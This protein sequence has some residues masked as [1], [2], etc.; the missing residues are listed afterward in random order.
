MSVR[1]FILALGREVGRVARRGRHVVSL[2]AMLG[3]AVAASSASAALI[4]SFPSVNA[5]PTA[6]ATPVTVLVGTEVTE[7]NYTVNSFTGTWSYT[8]SN[9]SLPD[10]TM[11]AVSAPG[12][13][14]VFTTGAPDYSLPSATN[15]GVNTSGATSSLVSGSSYNLMNL[16]FLVPQ[17]SQVGNYLI[18]FTEGVTPFTRFTGNTIGPAGANVSYVDGNNGQIPGTGVIAV[19]ESSATVLLASGA[20]MVS[21]AGVARRRSRSRKIGGRTAEIAG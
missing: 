9:A 14:P 7:Q 17:T 19:P 20:V 15:F 3:A 21:G 10:I 16:T 18:E 11:S 1:S 2:A 4:V 12:S 8:K 13:N 6:G 5:D